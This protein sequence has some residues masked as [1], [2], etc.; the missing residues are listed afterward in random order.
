[1]KLSTTTVL[2][3]AL[4]VLPILVL[5]VLLVLLV[6]VVLEV[7]VLALVLVLLIAEYHAPNS[8]STCVTSEDCKCKPRRYSSWNPSGIRRLPQDSNGNSRDPAKIR[9]VLLANSRKNLSPD[10]LTSICL[11]MKVTVVIQE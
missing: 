1:M 2:V 9:K 6:L 11:S 7:L 10:F 5:Q 8:A 4:L 3:L